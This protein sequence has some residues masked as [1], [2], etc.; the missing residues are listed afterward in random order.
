M[1]SLFRVH[2]LEALFLA[3]ARGTRF[4]GRLQISNAIGELLATQE[5][6]L[7]YVSLPPKKKQNEKMFNEQYVGIGLGWSKTLIIPPSHPITNK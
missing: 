5:S 6:F 3:V 4:P 7:P 2:F 1:V